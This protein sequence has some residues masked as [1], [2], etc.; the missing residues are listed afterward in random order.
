MSFIVYNRPL[1]RYVSP[2]GRIGLHRKSFVDVYDKIDA[3]QSPTGK[4]TNKYRET[5]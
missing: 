3:M 4:I 2:Q 1:G 5:S